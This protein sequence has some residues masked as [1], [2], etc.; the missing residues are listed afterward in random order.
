M[1]EWEAI[2]GPLAEIEAEQL[3]AAIAAFPWA[4][5]WYGVDDEFKHL[6]H[7]RITDEQA[8]EIKLRRGE[9]GYTWRAIAGW[10]YE[11][12]RLS[13]RVSWTMPDHQEVGSYICEGAALRLGDDPLADPLVAP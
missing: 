8:G 7:E 13:W 3:A 5:A 12:L 1:A 6:I 11:N 4:E 10:A 2:E 9:Q